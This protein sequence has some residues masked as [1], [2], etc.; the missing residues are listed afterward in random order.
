MDILKC[1]VVPFR[2][3]LVV[4]LVEMSRVCTVCTHPQAA[5]VNEAL[6][7]GTS[8]RQVAAS[9]GLKLSAVF[10]HANN[11][12]TDPIQRRPALVR[13]HEK[14]RRHTLRRVLLA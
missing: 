11:H 1:L 8:Y 6:A 12:L 4:Y 13:E 14:L 10:R 7:A 5:E 9:W 2:W 3:V